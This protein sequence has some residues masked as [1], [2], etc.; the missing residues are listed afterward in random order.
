MWDETIALRSFY[1]WKMKAKKWKWN[2]SISFTYL[3]WDFWDSISREFRSYYKHFKA[4]SPQRTSITC[5]GTAGSLIELAPVP[6]PGHKATAD[7][8]QQE[9]EAV[10]SHCIN[11]IQ[12]TQGTTITLQCAARS[13]YTTGLKL[14]IAANSV[15]TP[16]GLYSK[17]LL[18]SE[19]QLNNSVT[20]SLEHPIGHTNHGRW[21]ISHLLRKV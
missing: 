4:T 11:T 8:L 1:K 2:A 18:S 12:L 21:L 13:H 16:D 5:R 9:K 19:Q 10:A 6:S 17:G 14:D 7:E 3:D 15:E 20:H